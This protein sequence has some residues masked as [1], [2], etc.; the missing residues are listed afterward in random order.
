MKKISRIYIL[1]LSGF[2]SV[3]CVT[4]E[5]E[6]ELEPG[7]LDVIICSEKDTEDHG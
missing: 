2:L 1:V 6:P 3:A 5:K 7:C 4:Q